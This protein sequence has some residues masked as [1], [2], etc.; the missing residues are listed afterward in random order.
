MSRT[1]CREITSDSEVGENGIENTEVVSELCEIE[2]RMKVE[3][4]E[5]IRED[6]GRDL[7]MWR[8]KYQH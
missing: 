5:R 3:G 1:L 4:V 7:T 2:R 8:A 6:K